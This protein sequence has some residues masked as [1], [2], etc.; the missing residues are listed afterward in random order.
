LAGETE[1]WLRPLQETVAKGFFFKLHV[2]IFIKVAMVT[3]C[4]RIPEK[5]Q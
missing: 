1:E 3:L 2:F 4:W 5:K